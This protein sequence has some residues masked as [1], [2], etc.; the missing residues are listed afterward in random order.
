MIIAA[1]VLGGVSALGFGLTYWR[2]PH[3]ARDFITRHPLATDAVATAATYKIL[4]GTLTALTAAGFMS[5]GISS[6]L[7]IPVVSHRLRQRKKLKHLVKKAK[8]V[9][10]EVPL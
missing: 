4:G 6:L 2:L 3:A 8:P 7:F 5:V 10:V 9:Q 1:A